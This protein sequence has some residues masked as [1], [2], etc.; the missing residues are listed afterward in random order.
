M[1]NSSVVDEI[2][3]KLSRNKEKWLKGIES[4]REMLL[5]NLSLLS[6]FPAQTFHEKNR[7][8]FIL[9]RYTASGIVDPKTDRMH[10]CI[11]ICNGKTGLRNIV[12]CTHIDN[13]FSL[14]IDQNITITADRV[15][16]AGV[17]DDNLAVAALMTLPDILNQLNIKLDC[18][19][20]IV[21]TT[22]YHG[23]GD[24]EGIRTFLRDFPGKVDA[25]IN[26]TGITLGTLDY[27]SLSRV[28][29]D[30]H[31]ETREQ[32][33]ES[34]WMR[35]SES[36]AILVA[37]EVISSLYSI[38]LPKKPKTILN[39]GMISGGE[40]YST[41]SR[42]AEVNLEILSENNSLMDSLV[43]QISDCCTD[44]GA[45][46]S[47]NVTCDFFGR[48]DASGLS[49]AHPLIKTALGVFKILGHKP[50]MEYS[51]SQITVSLAQDIPSITLGLTEGVGGSTNR[52]FIEIAPLSQGILQLV[53]L[54][55]AIDQMGEICNG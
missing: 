24:F 31:C 46:H 16:G 33:M 10:N 19:I 49:S 15:H 51:N 53:L 22:R 28:R 7:A 36:S 50:R 27:F 54:L 11:G 18:N 8:E 40:R 44:I 43:E 14:G 5:G 38:P 23:R 20:I 32:E 47:A 1:T 42:E 21:G 39:L 41:I 17:A 6:E 45:K 52:S 35:M 26:L 12:V 4:T 25:V 30:I 9:T 55:T 2:L 29:C 34:S 13:Q 37:N 48:H 3:Q